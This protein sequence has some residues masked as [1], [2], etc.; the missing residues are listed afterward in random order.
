[1]LENNLKTTNSCRF[2]TNLNIIKLYSGL[3][4]FINS[5]IYI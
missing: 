1:M 5:L 4:Y 2:M 3:E